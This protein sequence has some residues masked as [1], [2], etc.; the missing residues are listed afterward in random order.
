MEFL[1]QVGV[2]IVIAIISYIIIKSNKNLEKVYQLSQEEPDKDRKSEDIV[3]QKEEATKQRQVGRS[4]HTV[5]SDLVIEQ[6][7]RRKKEQERKRERDF[8]IWTVNAKGR[9][10]HE[11]EVS[12]YPFTIGRQEDND[13]CIADGSVSS[14]H[15]EVTKEGERIILKDVGS[16]NKL[17]VNGTQTLEV[18]LRDGICVF[19]GNTQLY[20]ERIN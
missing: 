5:A 14:H 8:S 2:I 20:F 12:H 13:F 11:I 18:T 19:L 3:Y 10:E 15:A 7:K 1:A 4:A 17:F 16:S 9:L 6:E